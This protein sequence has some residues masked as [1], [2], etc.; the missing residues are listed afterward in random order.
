L[1][2]FSVTGDANFSMEATS[3]TVGGFSQPGVAR[4]L[5]EQSGSVETGLAQRFMWLF[6]KPSYAKFGT[7]EAVD[8]NFTAALGI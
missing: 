7:L 2:I 3:L 5:I 6:P 4:G 1:I 8:Q